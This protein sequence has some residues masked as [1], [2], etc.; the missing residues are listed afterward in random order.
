MSTLAP[1]EYLLTI[2]ARLD[3]TSVQRDVKFLVRTP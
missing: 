1:G 2:T 3:E